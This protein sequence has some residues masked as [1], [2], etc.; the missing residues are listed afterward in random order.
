MLGSDSF[1]LSIHMEAEDFVPVYN[2][3]ARVDIGCLH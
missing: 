3:A 1:S 2:H